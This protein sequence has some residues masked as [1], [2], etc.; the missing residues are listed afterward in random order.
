MQLGLRLALVVVA[1]ALSGTPASAYPQF[2]FSTLNSRCQNCHFSP[3]GGGL[4]NDYGRG[5]AGDT[6]SR[7]G[8]GSFL[9]GLWAPP[10][11]LQLG[12]DFRYAALAKYGAD[13]PELVQFP[14]QGDTYVRLAMGAVSA[15]LNVGPR[16]AARTPR[17]SPVRRMISREHYLTWQPDTSGIYARVGRYLA[18]FGLRLADHT[19]YTRKFTGFHV[20]EESYNASLGYFGA[21]WELHA[22]A[23]APADRFTSAGRR[24]SGGVLY[25]ETSL[26]DGSG[27]FGLQARAGKGHASNRYTAGTVA[28]W[29]FAGPELMLQGEADFILE[30]FAAETSPSRVQLASYLGLTHWPT[31]GLML[32][33]AFERFDPDLSASATFRDAFRLEAQLFPWAHWELHAMTKLEWQGEYRDPNLLS[34]LLLHYYL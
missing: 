17:Q 13:D 34:L 6:I 26:L 9:Y 27:A 31:R 25:A 28:K 4:I 10:E 24:E 19:V 23:F 32:T 18:P 16:A 33:A 11:W 30:T 22:T 8:D 20:V 21:G 12:A 15:Y 14:M 3:T 7:G 1:I 2:Q 5:E 29:Y